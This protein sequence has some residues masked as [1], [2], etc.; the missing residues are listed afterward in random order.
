MTKNDDFRLF[1]RSP[2]YSLIKKTSRLD[3][4]PLGA[5]TIGMLVRVVIEGELKKFFGRRKVEK[6]ISKLRDH[7]II[8]GFGKI[9]EFIILLRCTA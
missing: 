8:C 6:K 4:F 2:R 1:T 5:Y 9:G 7:Y 3:I